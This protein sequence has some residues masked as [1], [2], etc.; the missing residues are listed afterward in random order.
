MANTFDKTSFIPQKS[1]TQSRARKKLGGGLFFIISVIIFAV[2]VALSVGVF[3]YKKI[4]E[5]SKE[6]KAVSLS[7]SR[8]AFDPGLIADLTRLDKRMETTKRLLDG[9]ISL[10]PL[11]G[12]VEEFTLKNVRFSQFNFS[13]VDNSQ[14]NFSME[15]QALDYATVVAQSDL[16]GQSRFLQNQ[17]FSNV[18][19]DNSGNVIFHFEAKIDPSLISF[20]NEL[21]GV[22]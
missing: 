20:K 21:E 14:I 2:A 16:L 7:R 17:I 12:F 6:S 5:N 1:S 8:E 13:L 4:L 22:N 11:L 19:L 15:G 10:T 3:S 18:N 9:H